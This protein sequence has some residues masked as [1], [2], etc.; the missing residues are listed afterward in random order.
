MSEIYHY[1]PVTGA[2]LGSGEADIS[3]LDDELLIPAHATLTQPPERLEGQ[4]RVFQGGTWSYADI[5]AS[6]E[7]DAAPS[8]LTEPVLADAAPQ[9]DADTLARLAAAEEAVRLLTQGMQ[10]L[11]M[12]QQGD[13]S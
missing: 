8:P 9:V 11:N 12:K 10:A 5:V 7:T 3:P 4:A 2:Y 1:H 13:Q 6:V